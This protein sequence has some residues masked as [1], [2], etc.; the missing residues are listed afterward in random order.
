MI[1]TNTGTYQIIPITAYNPIGN[2][3]QVREVVITQIDVPNQ[4]IYCSDLGWIDWELPLVGE[5][6]GKR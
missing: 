5:K 6:R 2:P 3:Y 4:K 1:I